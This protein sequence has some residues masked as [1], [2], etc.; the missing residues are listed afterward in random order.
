MTPKEEYLLDC[1]R[2]IAEVSSESLIANFADQVIYISGAFP[3]EPSL[4][5]EYK[6]L[7]N[8]LWECCQGVEP[9]SY[10]LCERFEELDIK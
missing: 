9:P 4:T 3:E 7:V 5:K 6:L 1:L 8:E 10:N 2:H